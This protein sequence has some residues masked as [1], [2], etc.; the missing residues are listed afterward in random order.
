MYF[1]QRGKYLSI[2]CWDNWLNICLAYLVYRN[3]FQEF[4]TMKPLKRTRS[5]YV[6]LISAK[7]SSHKRD[8]K[9]FYSSLYVQINY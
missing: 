3:K 8:I 2:W 4:T 1:D 7:V 6:A 9:D 5:K